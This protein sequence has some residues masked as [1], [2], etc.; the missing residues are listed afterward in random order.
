MPYT[1]N[2]GQ[3]GNKY[4][5]ERAVRCAPGPRLPCPRRAKEAGAGRGGHLFGG[6]AAEG[7][8]LCVHTADEVD[9]APE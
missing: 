3:G 4:D 1:R 9:G 5:C 6:F 8:P 2:S 7:A